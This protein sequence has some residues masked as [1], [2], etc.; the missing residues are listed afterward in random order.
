MHVLITDT[1]PEAS[2]DLVRCLL[3]HLP[4][5]H[6]TARRPKLRLHLKGVG[7]KKDYDPPTYTLLTLH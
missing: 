6:G 5:L 2:H 1:D 4:R 7:R 3:Q